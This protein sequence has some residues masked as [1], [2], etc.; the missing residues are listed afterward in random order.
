MA[1]ASA[2]NVT[3]RVT[4]GETRGKIN[5]WEL[6]SW[7]IADADVSLSTDGTEQRSSLCSLYLLF[8]GSSSDS[9][10]GIYT[11]FKTLSFG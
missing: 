6:V 8:A 2:S 4:T 11:A 5:M 1:A 7:V 3:G 9:S 10:S